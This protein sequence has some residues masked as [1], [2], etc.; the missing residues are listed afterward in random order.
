MEHVSWQ[1]RYERLERQLQGE[2]YRQILS[3]LQWGNPFLE[4]FES[5]LDV[6]AFMRE[7]GSEDPK[8]DMVL[9]P[10]LR[11]HGEG[12]DPRCGSDRPG[13]EYRDQ[14]SLHVVYLRGGHPEPRPSD[15][16]REHQETDDE[17]PNGSKHGHDRPRNR[18]AT[19]FV[20]HRRTGGHGSS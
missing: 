13:E 3:E 19:V 16:E 8:N 1:E 4:Q 9:R 7:G 12:G 5:W 2:E 10:I 6:I 17:L 11:M 20:C 18:V 14:V 15:H